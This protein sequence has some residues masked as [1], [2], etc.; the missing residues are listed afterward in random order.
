MKPV[1]SIIT[2]VN[3]IWAH[4]IERLSRVA[5]RNVAPT[6]RV[7]PV[8]WLLLILSGYSLIIT[9]CA[10]TAII[11][12]RTGTATVI[13]SDSKISNEDH[14]F[15]SVVGCK[16]KPIGN[17]EIVAFSA[18][19]RLPDYD[20]YKIAASVSNKDGPL[21]T[22]RAFVAAMDSPLRLTREKVLL[23]KSENTV[24]L[25]L[26]K[27]YIKKRIPWLSAT[28]VGFDGTSTAY[29]FVEFTLQDDPVHPIAVTG[30]IE[31]A[32]G[33]LM[34][35]SLVRM[36]VHSLPR[37]EAQRLIWSGTDPIKGGINVIRREIRNCPDKVGRPIRVVR[38]T[39]TG[40]QWARR[41]TKACSAIPNE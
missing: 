33:C 27:T 22:A 12:F 35:K 21:A 11:I 4:V 30:P 10:A 13:I 29:A 31:C 36:G 1:D 40:A 16:V 7:T 20:A 14:R 37:S 32:D 34:D 9:P 2:H 15:L 5:V 26:Y 28:F 3:I 24:V 8:L 17:R 39:R 38:V 25:G 41:D 19:P 23:A 6:L 18:I